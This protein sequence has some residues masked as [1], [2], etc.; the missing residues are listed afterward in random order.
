MHT[1]MSKLHRSDPPLLRWDVGMDEHLA[2]LFQ[3]VLAANLVDEEGHLDDVEVLGV[4]LLVLVEV[5]C[6]HLATG[7]A[8]VAAGAGLWEEELVD[9]DGAGVDAVAG[10]LLDHALRLVEAEELGDADADKG[11]E[12]GVLELGVDL[13]NGLAQRLELLHHVVEVL[14]VGQLAAGAEEAVEQGAVLRRELRDLGQGLFEDRG[15]LEEAQGVA[16]GGRVEDDGFVGERL[17]LLEDFGKGHGLVD[18]GD[19]QR[20]RWSVRL[21]ERALLAEKGRKEWQKE[22]EEREK[23]SERGHTANAR[24]CIMPPMPPPMELTSS[25]SAWPAS[26]SCML[27]L[28]SISMALRLSKPLT[29]RAS[30]PN[31]CEKASE[32]LWAGSVE[33][34]RTERRTLASW[35]AS[36][37][38]VVVL[39]TPPLPPTKIQ[40]RERWSSSDCS[41]GSRASSAEMTADDMVGKR[42]AVGAGEQTRLS[43]RCGGRSL[44]REEEEEEE[45]K[46]GERKDASG[47]AR[48]TMA[49]LSVT[50]CGRGSGGG[51]EVLLAKLG[52]PPSGFGGAKRRCPSKAEDINGEQGL[53]VYW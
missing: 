47:S 27:P 39:P 11:G 6:L 10:E 49:K 44:V 29:R 1:F 12:V 28:G 7:V 43:E 46:R 4:E 18:A 40:R 16:G 13:G 20:E 5:L 33:M 35:M 14:A 25:C 32:R 8:L 34:S 38:D 48:K 52:G 19:L 53:Q 24:S 50:F 23:K 22:R 9:D 36:E 31:F 41:E 2:K 15:K 30:L 51:T 42:G 17:D 26:R 45:R 3:L 37:H 21:R